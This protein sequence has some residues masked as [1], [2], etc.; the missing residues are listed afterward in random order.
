MVKLCCYIL[1]EFG[2]ECEDT[3]SVPKQF[4]AI[5]RHYSRPECESSRP[6]MLLAFAKILNA[7]GS[8]S[9][10]G[11]G[12]GRSK[13]VTQQII[14]IFEELLDSSNIELQQ[15]ACEFLALYK[16]PAA[17]DKALTMMP[18]YSIDRQGVNPLVKRLKL[19][20]SGSRTKSKIELPT[21][22][23]QKTVKDDNTKCAV[24]PRPMSASRS[25]D[26]S[27]LEVKFQPETVSKGT[28]GE[29]SRQSEGYVSVTS[30]E[31]DH[32]GPRSPV[33]ASNLQPIPITSISN[34]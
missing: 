31:R 7:I 3:I 5:H 23:S 32:S 26:D 17:A 20:S 33:K 11:S 9:Q 25:K 21:R 30:L 15:R 13:A 1:G 16:Y 10:S 2:H 19:Q 18:P 29:L 6:L 4:W 24:A 12:G 14:T 34:I 8:S 27:V 22:N 28:S